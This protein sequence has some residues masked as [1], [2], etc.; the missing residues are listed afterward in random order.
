MSIRVLEK[1]WMVAVADA[2][3]FNGWSWIDTH[4][5][6]RSQ[7]RWVGPQANSARGF[8]D[9]VACRPPR[10]LFLEIKREGG[11]VSDE[12]QAWIGRLQAAGQEAHIV[13]LPGGWHFL[14]DLLAPDPVQMSL[15]TNSTGATWLPHT[16]GI[17][18]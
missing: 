6:R 8:P 16:K 10:T 3:D 7:G 1:D 14:D 18:G 4:P 12:Q 11:R 9:V 2:L 17:E 15:T 5:T 13:T